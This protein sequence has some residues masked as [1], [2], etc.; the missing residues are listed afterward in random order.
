MKCLESCHV[1]VLFENQLC[2]GV[3]SISIMRIAMSL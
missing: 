3:C 2:V 1:K